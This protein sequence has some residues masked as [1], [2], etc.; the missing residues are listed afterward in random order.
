MHDR[1]TSPPP[2]ARASASSRPSLDSTDPPP[3]PQ[4]RGGQKAA[5]LIDRDALARDY[6]DG[7]STV[8][9]ARRH[10]V[11]TKTIS[12]LLKAAGIRPRSVAEARQV[13]TRNAW[14]TLP[15]PEPIKDRPEITDVF[16]VVHRAT[17]RIPT[18]FGFDVLRGPPLGGSGNGIILTRDLVA[19]LERHRLHPGA[20]GLPLS[21]AS[22]TRLRRRLT[23]DWHADNQDWWQERR[24]ELATARTKDFAARHGADPAIVD[25]VRR[26]LHGRR[27]EPRDTWLDAAARDLILSPTLSLAQIALRLGISRAYVSELRA[28][29][30]TGRRKP[31][32][33]RTRRAE[34]APSRPAK[35]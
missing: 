30:R 28:E 5:R 15:K 11:S 16:G 7:A 33:R 21:P 32:S 23:L 9:L 18:F 4:R 31:D 3:R 20:C 8:D 10:D 25:H 19:H 34:V 27:R 17:L 35:S 1:P 2:R 29:F 26:K 24:E 14:L 12:T 13:R 6:Q 22:L